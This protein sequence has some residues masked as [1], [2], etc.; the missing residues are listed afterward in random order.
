MR[1]EQFRGY[2]Y[3][4]PSINGINEQCE[5]CHAK[6]LESAYIYESTHDMLAP[7]LI[8]EKVTG[9]AAYRWVIV[10]REVF[11]THIPKVGGSNPLP[12]TKR[13]QG[14]TV[15]L[16]QGLVCFFDLILIQKIVKLK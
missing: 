5:N 4:S 2:L 14:L 12:A 8:C 13:F 3:S 11:Q 10:I 15:Y 6:N 9:I 1:T 16:L 7:L